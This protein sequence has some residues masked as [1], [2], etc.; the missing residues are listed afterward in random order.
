MW[1][2]LWSEPIFDH[3]L[4]F[5]PAAG[6]HRGRGRRISF[7]HRPTIYQTQRDEEM[8][9]GPSKDRQRKHF[10]CKHINLQIWRPNRSLCNESCPTPF[11]VS[12]LDL[13]HPKI[14]FHQRVFGKVV[15]ALTLLEHPRNPQPICTPS[16]ISC[17]VIVQ[18]SATP[19]HNQTS[20]IYVSV[21]E[22]AW[23]GSQAPSPPA[24]IL[25]DFHDG[26]IM[27]TKV[28]YMYV[29]IYL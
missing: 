19:K 16:Y 6:K 23:I 8:W 25:P 4:S 28:Y 13:W 27:Q 20:L 9:A 15:S 1:S 5:A 10:Y 24:E 12:C 26:M 18:S 11:L 22:E 7:E 14:A 3:G 17:N 21:R 2:E 29:Y